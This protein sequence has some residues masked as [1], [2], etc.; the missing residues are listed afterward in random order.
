MVGT[1]LQ[2]VLQFVRALWG[3]EFFPELVRLDFAGVGDLEKTEAERGLI[4][5]Q[6]F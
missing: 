2:E 6:H 1:R 3:L 5:H 4:E